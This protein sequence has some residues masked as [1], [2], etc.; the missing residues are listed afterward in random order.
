MIIMIKLVN[1]QI[2]LVPMGH[3]EFK[4]V[5]MNTSTFKTSEASILYEAGS[6]CFSKGSSLR[7]QDACEKFSRCGYDCLNLSQQM[8]IKDDFGYY[9]L[10][11]KDKEIND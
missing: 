8:W 9:Y 5:E 7:C 2:N 4:P 6:F 11:S 3:R 1:N 10:T